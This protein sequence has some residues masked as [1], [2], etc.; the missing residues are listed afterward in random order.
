MKTPAG[1][2]IHVPF[3]KKKC[4]YCD[5]YSLSS[6]AL[7]DDYC[8]AVERDIL[9]FDFGQSAADTVYFGGGTPSILGAERLIGILKAAMAAGEIAE[10]AEVTCEVNPATI[11]FDGLS[12]LRRGGFNRLSI[13]IQS[14][15]DDELRLL[16]R[17]HDFEQAKTCVLDAK[18]AGFENISCDL[19]YGLP[20]QLI[21][22]FLCSCAS[23]A[24]LGVQHISFYCLKLE[25]G[26]PMAGQYSLDDLP[27]EDALFE[28]YDLAAGFFEGL[29]F[30]Q[31]EISNFA[32]PGYPSRHNLKY[33]TGADYAGFGPG[34]SSFW[35]GSRYSIAPD[36]ADY[37]SQGPK[38]TEI[39]AIG[40]EEALREYIMLR[41]RLCAGIAPADFET[42]FGRPFAPFAAVLD[43]LAG[44]AVFQ[45][46]R[47]R[48]T[49][50]G[51]FV[52]NAIISRLIDII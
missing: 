4:A 49:R 45:N 43:S 27:G 29:G 10:D 15:D 47:Y 32:L 24:A 25:E 16:G 30:E 19:I 12:R 46:G 21:E 8:E 18:A 31:Y 14:A 6:P 1:I 33:W 36:L 23:I 40:P 13:G 3:C 28:M 50:R 48:L 34:S 37:L 11:G 42:C 22:G 26:T 9:S 39:E 44:L 52:S 35:K 38:K 5:F 51:F 2:Y 41:L 17:I 20:G 7:T